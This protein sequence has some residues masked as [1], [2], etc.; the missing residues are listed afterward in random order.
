M[1]VR[2]SFVSNSSSSSYII[3][4]TKKDFDKSKLKVSSGL[5]EDI[6]LSNVNLV[7]I[8]HISGDDSCN[9]DLD[10]EFYELRNKI[11]K[12]KED[13]KIDAIIRSENW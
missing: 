2:E 13:G 3:I 4:L 7:L 12:M 1:K 6:K 10:D 11:R 9:Q 5:A 8:S